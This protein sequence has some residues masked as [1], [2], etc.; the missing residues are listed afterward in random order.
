MSYDL[1]RMERSYVD[2]NKREYELTKHVSLAVTDPSALIRLRTTGECFVELPE[3][4]F[5]LDHPGQYLRRLKTV[6]VTIPCVAGPYTSINC[7]LTLLRNSV[8]TSSDPEPEYARTGGEDPRFRDNLGA[9]QSIVTS[10]G[11][12]DSGLF[13]TNLRDERY[14]PF[15]GAGAVSRWR[16]QLPPNFNAFDFDTISDVVLHVRYTARDGGARLRSAASEAVLGG[17]AV[18]GARLLSMSG[19][20]G[21]E[22]FRF[23]RPVEEGATARTLRVDLNPSLFPFRVRDK[24]IAISRVDMLLSMADGGEFAAP[25]PVTI[26]AGQEGT[27]QAPVMLKKSPLLGQ[28]PYLSVGYGE[29]EEQPLGPWTFSVPEPAW[30]DL[31]V[32]DVLLI[33]YYRASE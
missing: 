33:V 9:I 7:T 2:L 28:V 14:L 23:T 30:S 24:T 11:Q 32:D 4:L 5:D 20:S 16:V 17:S 8:R 27:P 22:W 26:T 25:V 15:E 6:S 13:E 3:A 21:D 19:D 12:N 18:E 31:A 29:G 1:Q 10:S